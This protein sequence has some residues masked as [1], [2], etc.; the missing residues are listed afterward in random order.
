MSPAARDPV[1]VALKLVFAV[2]AAA[3]VFTFAATIYRYTGYEIAKSFLAD[4][5]FYYLVIANNIAAGLGSIFDGVAATNGY[6]PVWLLVCVAVAA[7]IPHDL[8][9]ETVYALQGLLVLGTGIAIR[10]ALGRVNPFGATVIASLFLS[11]GAVRF[12]LMNGMESA[13][14][15]ALLSLLLWWILR[16]KNG[17]LS[18]QS[19]PT[20]I[21]ATVLL[22]AIA[23]T[24]LE[25]AI[26]SVFFIGWLI[27]FAPTAQSRRYAYGVGCGLALIG[28]AY[29]AL[30][31]A[32]VQWPVPL[33]GSVKWAGTEIPDVLARTANFH[34]TTFLRP[35]TPIGPLP[36]V[37]LELAAGAALL[38]ALVLSCRLRMVGSTGQRNTFSA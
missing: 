34:L 9:I 26:V 7:L 23:L 30:N 17:Q 14:G 36:N 38:S 22:A 6:H 5:T 18:I 3:H 16:Q 13:L 35:V 21:G 29:V 37:W 20:A 2:A 24:R 12:V 1:S 32:I 19:K 8:Q 15:A 11:S 4:D 28:T 25:M 10:S 33:S 27:A 31:L